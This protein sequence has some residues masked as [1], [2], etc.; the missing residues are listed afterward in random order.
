MSPPNLNSQQN[1]Q[2]IQNVHQ[3]W[4]SLNERS[5]PKI[6]LSPPGDTV[7]VQ[8]PGDEIIFNC[9]VSYTKKLK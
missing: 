2:V 9:T 6:E 3:T 8:N 5:F 4:I 7:K 1:W